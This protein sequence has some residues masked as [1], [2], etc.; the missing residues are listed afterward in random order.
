LYVLKRDRNKV[1]IRKIERT[2]NKVVL[3]GWT[4]ERNPSF[5]LFC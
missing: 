1:R 2:T 3:K 5:V 4:E